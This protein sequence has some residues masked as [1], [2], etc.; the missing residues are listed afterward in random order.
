[1]MIMTVME[2]IYIKNKAKHRG[3]LARLIWNLPRTTCLAQFI[4]G[5][6]RKELTNRT[7]TH[8]EL[9]R[10]NCISIL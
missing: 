5:K 2:R 8:F 7:H 6:I 9:S 10:L 3:A 4:V 1:M